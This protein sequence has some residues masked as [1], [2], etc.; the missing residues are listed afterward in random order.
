MWVKLLFP[1]FKSRQRNTLH[2]SQYAL[3]R[4]LLDTTIIPVSLRNDL[5]KP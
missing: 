4:H 2:G 5:E 3:S 1:W